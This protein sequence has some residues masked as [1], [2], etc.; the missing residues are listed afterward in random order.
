MC[1]GITTLI[2]YF[3]NYSM[4]ASKTAETSLF[5]LPTH[6]LLSKTSS[7]KI[8]GSITVTIISDT[9]MGV[10]LSQQQDVSGS[11]I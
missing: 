5:L 7:L 9:Y 3:I 8:K 2:S 11:Y 1:D 4:C 10:L 6:S